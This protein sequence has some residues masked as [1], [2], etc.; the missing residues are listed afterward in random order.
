MDKQ[1]VELIG[2]MRATNQR[3]TNLQ[4]Q[5]QQPRLATEADVKPDMKI[6]KRTEDATAGRAKHGDYSSSARV[7]KT[8]CVDQLL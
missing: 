8:R 4:H 5:A 6:R 1:L 3:L 7:I 2:I